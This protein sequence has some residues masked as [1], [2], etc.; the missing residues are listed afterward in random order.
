MRVDRDRRLNEDFSLAEKSHAYELGFL[1]RTLAALTADGTPVTELISERDYY[2]VHPLNGRFDRWIRDRVSTLRI[3][4]GY[5]ENLTKV[6]FQFLRRDGELLVIPISDDAKKVEPNILGVAEFVHQRG[7]VLVQS[8]A[9][10]GRRRFEVGF[11]NGSYLAGGSE[12]SIEEFET[13]LRRILRSEFLVLTDPPS[14]DPTLAHA[15]P[16]ANGSIR[17]VVGNTGGRCARV[18]EARITL[19][20]H[21]D[22]NDAT[23]DVAIFQLPLD[24]TD[25]TYAGARSR[26]GDRIVDFDSHPISGASF[27]GRLASWTVLRTRLEEICRSVPQIAFAEFSIAERAGDLEITAIHASPRYRS[28]VGFAPETV[29]F[30]RSRFEAKRSAV[31]GIWMRTRRWAHNF[32]LKIRRTYAKAFFPRGLVPYQSVRWPGDV[33]R[34]FVAPNGVPL[35]TKLWAYRHGFLSYRVPQYGVTPENW[36]HLVSDFEYRWLRHINLKYRYWLEDK[37]SL[38]HLASRFSDCLPAYYFHITGRAGREPLVVPMMDCPSHYE[39]TLDGVF[40]L[41]RELGV[42]ALK[43]DEGSHGD[44]FYRLDFVAGLYYLNGELVGEGDVARILIQPGSQYL[45]TEFIRMHPLLSEIYPDAVNTLRMVVLKDDGVT[46][47]I[48]N[49]YLRIGTA[50]S[51]FVDN[52]AAG[53]MFAQ[54]DIA[55]GSF[56][57]AQRLIK[58]KVVPTPTHP[59]TGVLI[60][61]TLPNWTYVTQRVLEIARDLP[62]L[63]YLGFD[64]AITQEGFKLP[65]VNRFPDYPRIEKLTPETIAYLL[66]K[67]RHKKAATRYRRRWYAVNLPK[68]SDEP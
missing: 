10:K 65:E 54:V 6:H 15:F 46:P 28:I 51:G 16:G 68:R 40:A 35:R 27:S 8:S 53:G 49:A 4:G 23:H 52:T 34:D 57:N 12:V 66:R 11:V 63:E 61:G 43:P 20:E 22:R 60:E 36:E 39:E 13:L 30:L 55:T 14:R 67:V 38:K 31:G 32:R 64:V 21:V 24:V 7:P 1:P 42:V 58:G 3:F 56:G 9:Y 19:T 18:M 2:F 5:S 33:L 26:I 17:A 37:I 45:V 47:T 62:Q 41:V 59:D 44:G 50:A 29:S 48:G 25:G